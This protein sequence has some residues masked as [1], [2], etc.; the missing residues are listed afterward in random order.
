MIAVL[1]RTR[2]KTYVTGVVNAPKR[3]DESMD[4]TPLVE[5]TV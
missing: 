4:E 1:R 3:V 5:R 2:T